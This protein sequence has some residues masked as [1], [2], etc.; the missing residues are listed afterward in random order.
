MKQGTPKLTY[1]VSREGGWMMMAV[2]LILDFLPFMVLIGAVALLFSTLGG[3]ACLDKAVLEPAVAAAS[4]ASERLGGGVFGNAIGTI[5]GALYMPA[6]N[7]NTYKCIGAAGISLGSGFWLSP[8]IFFVSAVVASL[9][10]FTLFPL[11]FYFG[12]HYIMVSF[13][14]PGKVITNASSFMITTILKWMPIVN[15][16]PLPVYTLTVWRHVQ[17]SRHEDREEHREKLK[18]SMKALK[19]KLHAERANG[20]QSSPSTRAEYVRQMEQAQYLPNPE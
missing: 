4:R 17:I 2:A 15:L 20:A 11:W 1:R 14:H 10:A 9:I 5:V 12:K 16:F 19:Q 7:I 18:K 6:N 3:Q 8:L 13:L